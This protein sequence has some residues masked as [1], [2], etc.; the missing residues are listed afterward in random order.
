M[1]LANWW[2]MGRIAEALK[3]AQQ[4]RARAAGGEAAPGACAVAEV[5][6]AESAGPCPSPAGKSPR[7][8]GP[9]AEPLP[10]SAP[11]IPAGQ[12]DPRVVSWH[13]PAG[14]LSEKYR[15]TRT[16][17]LTAGTSS[18]MFAVTSAVPG[19]GKTV[20]VA[21]L[22][23][24]L[25]ELR[26]IRVAMIDADFRGRGL[27]KLFGVRNEPG[28]A[29][30]VR[31]EVRLSDICL[32]V[33]RTNLLLIPAGRTNGMSTG[34]LLAGEKAATA[35]REIDQHFG[36]GLIDAPAATTVAD[37]GMIAPLCHSA[38]IVVR[39]GRAPETLLARCV[40]MLQSNG[41]PIIGSLCVG[42]SEN[43]LAYTDSQELCPGA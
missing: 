14:Q 13:D 1:A 2:V 25:A 6:P 38:I 32:P 30:L 18:R 12:I 34:E 29:E 3:R 7:A 24:A 23:F 10:V 19:E 4:E 21:N 43:V 41:V 15:S 20:T 26:H 9:E 39:M 37:I 35:F 36:Y 17:L 16:R 22:G 33:V 8:R 5:P 28:L 31:G 11:S 27:S 42:C 40:H